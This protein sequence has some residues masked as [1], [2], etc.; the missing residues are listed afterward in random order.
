M[1]SSSL[2]F[3]H[4]TIM[5]FKGSSLIRET[6]TL[7]FL[8]TN[9]R[10]L[11]HKCPKP[12]KRYSIISAICPGDANNTPRWEIS[13]RHVNQMFGLP[14]LAPFSVEEQDSSLSSSLY[15]KV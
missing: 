6:Q 12:A 2:V 10:M 8:A 14:L 1:N 3:Y 11:P 15:L 7:H 9:S 13:K 5:G 4:S